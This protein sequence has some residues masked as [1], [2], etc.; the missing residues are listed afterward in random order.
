M[1]LFLFDGDAP[2]WQ[3]RDLPSPQRGFLLEFE[4]GLGTQLGFTTAAGLMLRGGA[5]RRFGY[6]QSKVVRH[7]SPSEAPGGRLQRTINANGGGE[8]EHSA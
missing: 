4:A 8:A 6:A 1:G 2:G 3:G 7:S 5:T